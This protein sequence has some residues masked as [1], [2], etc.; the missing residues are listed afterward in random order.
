MPHRSGAAEG[1]A[2]SGPPG[3]VEAVHWPPSWRSS[4]RIAANDTAET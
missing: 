3:E 4:D 1:H 2:P